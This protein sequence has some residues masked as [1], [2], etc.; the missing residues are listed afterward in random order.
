MDKSLYVA[1]TGASQAM[2]SQSIH[3]NNLANVSTNG[4]RAELAQT[5]AM[6]VFGEGFPSLVYSMTES[7]GLNYEEGPIIETGR[8]LDVSIKGQG[9]LTVIDGEGNEAYTRNGDLMID[10]NGQVKTR[11]GQ[12]VM[13]NAGPLV[14]PPYEKLDIS[15]DGVISIRALGQGPETLAAL[16]SLKLVNPDPRNLYKGED[17]LIRLKDGGE[18]ISDP[19]IQIMTGF[20]EGSNVNPVESLTAIISTARQFELQVKLMKSAEENDETAAR[21]MQLR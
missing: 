13:G 18:S 1:M 11:F 20:L 19:K 8:D 7:P 4:F 16:D 17:G 15:V 9:W 12:Q 6:P 14:I 3:A 10:A 5:R 2:R 21:I